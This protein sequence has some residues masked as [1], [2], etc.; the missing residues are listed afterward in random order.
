MSAINVII[1][2]FERDFG[3]CILERAFKDIPVGYCASILNHEKDMPHLKAAEQVWHS[4]TQ[5]RMED[6]ETDYD[7]DWNQIRPL[8]EKL[9]YDMRECEAIV[10]DMFVRFERKKT[11]SYEQRK[12]AYLEHLRYWNHIL[13]EKQINLF[14]SS[15]IPHQCFDNVIEHLC[16]LKGI[17]TFYFYPDSMPDVIVSMND[18]LDPAPGI[19]ERYAE[20]QKKFAGKDINEIDL[21]PRLQKYFEKQTSGGKAEPFYMDMFLPHPQG[22]PLRE[23]AARL[24]KFAT[25]EPLNALRRLFTSSVWAR[26]L[27]QQYAYRF[28]EQN[29]VQPDL[30]KKYVY[31]ALH[32]QPECSTAPMA[33]A[34]V[35]QELIV[36]MLG[37][38]LPEDVIIYVKEHPHQLESCRSVTF[39]KDLLAVRNV[40]FVPRTFNTYHLIEQAQA[41]AT[42]TGTVGLEALLRGKPVFLFGHRFYQSAPGTHSIHTTKD[43][44]QAVEAIFAKQQKPVLRD[45]KLFLKAYGDTFIEGYFNPFYEKASSLTPEEN[46]RNVGDYLA[47]KLRTLQ[48]VLQRPTK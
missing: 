7:V 48:P 17:P 4:A 36:Q 19:S 8:D 46:I 41:I 25:R 13:E 12:R 1:K 9:I 29:T 2:G 15:H 40:R 18:W 31:V 11:I 14:L 6:M 22:R 38:C 44:Q 5:L 45:I 30:S 21:S 35:N 37:A 33:G 27:R 16:K 10:L 39:Y 24:W 26:K 42:A 20:L 34:F 28:Y 43:C 3:A 32:V 47:E 23:R